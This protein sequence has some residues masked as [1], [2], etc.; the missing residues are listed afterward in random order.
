MS[1]IHESVSK[2][3]EWDG[4][5]RQRPVRADRVF[6][7][8]SA[9]GLCAA[10][11]LMECPVDKALNFM[12]Q[13]VREMQSSYLGPFSPNFLLTEHLRVGIDFLFPKHAHKIATNRLHLSVTG[14]NCNKIITHYDTREEF[15][16][17]SYI[18]CIFV[19]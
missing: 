15:I 13:M 10:V 5:V 8:S 7:G 4:S 3:S 18:L 6:C 9:G 1:D 19:Q 12:R 17:V 14:N 16:D 11:T 2:I